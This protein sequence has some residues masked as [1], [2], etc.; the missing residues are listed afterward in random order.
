MFSISDLIENMFYICG[1]LVASAY[2]FLYG[3]TPNFVNIYTL[4]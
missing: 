1:Y 2:N 4:K 3:R